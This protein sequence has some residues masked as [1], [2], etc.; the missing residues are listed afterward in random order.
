MKEF[1]VGVFTC[2]GCSVIFFVIAMFAVNVKVEE[3]EQQMIE[4]QKTQ[5][6]QAQWIAENKTVMQTYKFF[7]QSWQ[8]II[9]MEKEN[10]K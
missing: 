1:W 8:A 2:L 4:L 3:L 6:Q 10:G 9:D 5:E 7:N